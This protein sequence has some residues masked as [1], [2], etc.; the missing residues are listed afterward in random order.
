MTSGVVALAVLALAGCSGSSSAPPSALDSTSGPAPTVQPSTSLPAPDGVSPSVTTRVLTDGV[1]TDH[2]LPDQDATLRVPTTPG[3]APLVVIVPGG[4]W[5]TADPTDYVPLAQS[6][7]S[8][9]ISTTLI[10]YSTTADGAQFPRPIDDV[11]CAVRWSVFQLTALGYPPSQT[12]V[13]GHSAGGQLAM[14][15]ALTSDKFGGDCPMPPVAINGAIGMAG[16]YDLADAGVD[17][18]SL[19]AAIFPDGGT[20]EERAQYSPLALVQDPANALP[21]VGVLLMQGDSDAIVPA[22]QQAAMAAALTARGITPV[23]NILPGVQHNMGF[24][25]ALE[26]APIIKFWVLGDSYAPAVPSDSAVP[27]SPDAASA[28]PAVG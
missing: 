18:G 12:I 2:Y 27:L 21:S 19:P 8:S 28:S 20:P 4:G 1:L 15:V 13:A 26:I 6:L 22:T 17:P 16:V 25:L 9:G 23:V 24:P 5:A 11:A 3:A 14:E 10:T 7:Q